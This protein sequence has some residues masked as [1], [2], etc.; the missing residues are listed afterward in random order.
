MNVYI[1]HPTEADF[2]IKYEVWTCGS[3]MGASTFYAALIAKKQ[4]IN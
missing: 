1:H 2:L 3:Y 4:T